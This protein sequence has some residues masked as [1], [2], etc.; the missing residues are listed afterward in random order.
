MS[1]HAAFDLVR[2]ETIPEIASDVRLY[3]H[4]KTGAE[5]MSYI[6]DDE[7]KVFGITFKTPPEDSTG[8]AHIL[9][10]SVLCGSRKYPV[11][12]PFVELIKSSMNTFLNA[13]TFP[14]KTAYPVASQNL[15]DFYNLV[16]VYLDAVFFP[17]ISEDTF[18]QEGWHYEADGTQMPLAYK[19]VVF[20]EMKGAYS[21]PA[22]L[23]GK[24]SQLSLYPDNAYGV[25][26]GGDPRAIPDLT[27]D[28]FKNFH[29]RFYHPS[30]SK[31]V[32]YGD[33]PEGRRL[34]MLDEYLS[35]FDAAPVDATVRL[36]P[37]FHE[38]RHIESTYAATEAEPG[39]KT[40]MITVNWM[41][42]EIED[43]E[44]VL[45]LNVLEHV[46]VGTPAAPLRK[47]LT[48]SGLGEGLTG[49]GLADDL[50]QPYF[51]VGLKGID[52]GDGGK[53][54]TLVLD[55]LRKLAA[56]GID[57]LTIEASMN[58][59]EFALR[60]NNTGSFPR[61]MALMFRTM[62]NWLHGG[63][64]FESLTYEKPLEALKARVAAGE[65]VFET[66]VDRHLNS[67]THRVTVLLRADT[68]QAEREVAEERERLDG[69]AEGLDEAGREDIVEITAKLKAL[70]DTADPP[71][72]LAKIPSLG[73]KDL[74]RV[75]KPIPI[76]R[77][78][79]AGARLYTHPLPTNGVIYLDLAF[80]LRRVP[81]ELLP[82][83]SLFSRALFQTGTARE[84][85][86]SLTQ[87]IGRSTGGVGASRSIS[88][89]RDTASV[90]AWLFIRGKAVPDKADEL[91]AIITD[92]LTS[93][94]L[95]NRERIKQMA[96][97][98]KAGFESGIAGRGNGIAAGRLG[99]SLNPA[100]WANEQSSGVSY[101]FFL[102][103]LLKGID[104]EEGWLRIKAAL[105]A[106]RDLVIDRQ[107]MV[108]NVTSDA[109][110]WNAFRPKLEGFVA[111]LPASDVAPRLWL[112]STPVNEGLTFPGQVNYV[113][114]GA[115]LY[116]LGYEHTGATAVALRQ[117]NTTYLWDKVRVQGGAYGGS[118][119]F[120][121][122]SGGFVF[123]SYRD[124]NLL[125]TLAA[126]D[127]AAQWLKQG[128]GEQD[129]VRSIIGAIGAIDTY[130]LPDAKGFTS[131]MWELTGNTDENR[132]LRREQI[133]D[134]TTTDVSRFA[135]VLGEVARAGQIVVLGS[136]TAIKTANQERGGFLSV[137]KVL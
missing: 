43:P 82:Y 81:A 60:E 15:Q 8:V 26:S 21:S 14:D 39:K 30:N 118:A 62:K 63:D 71:E 29:R 4:K 12:K 84:D 114:K 105:Y 107:S 13:M 68:T 18:R 101:L 79:L 19:G 124:P 133:L 20:N 28:Y 96:L 100:S 102:R 78:T 131:L 51:T 110:L 122:F 119:G 25:N 104:S 88:M 72:A 93:A 76:E 33:D 36:Q 9:E 47:A 59:F 31:I 94:N 121:P 129:L 38:P 90:A 1:V 48:D 113:A 99:A 92:V 108:L 23:L 85:F 75:N 44:T 123:T 67:N 66:L 97:E 127:G 70:Q 40:G 98:E 69:V 64:P 7:N 41:L 106:I 137:T 57:P 111:A 125:E 112:P 24:V 53:V 80:D 45:A 126:Y 35:Q 22:A 46:L 32:F 6:N 55:T 5:V 91:L 27:Y 89:M 16:D 54:E 61:G 37:R 65:P 130:R 87:R 73:L 52:E 120:D 50:R 116:T 128:I 74:D 49:S 132:Q 117:L 109:G 42:D 34:E 103:E 2:D 10:H 115:N 56:D 136:E 11:K 83:L 135:D 134:A 17:L 58:S 86:V 95:D 3:R 77:D